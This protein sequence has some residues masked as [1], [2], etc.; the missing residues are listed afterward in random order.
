MI[1]SHIRRLLDAASS[2]AADANLPD[3]LRRIVRSACDLVDARYGALGVLGPDQKFSEFITVGIDQAERQGMGELP[4]GHGVLGLV[5]ADP[6][7]QRLADL[8]KHPDA[9]GFPPGH[10]P[11][12]SFLGVPIRVRETVFGNLYLTEKRGGEAFTERDEELVVALATAV[13][14]TIENAILFDKALRRERWLEASHQVTSALLA[15]EDPDATFRLIA[16]R[17]R[18]V[19]GASVTAIARPGAGDRSTLVFEVVEAEDPREQRQWAGVTVPVEGTATG[20][21]FTSGRPVVVRQYGDHVVAQE[22]DSARHIPALVKD[23]DSAVAVPLTVGA[24]TLGVLLVAKFRDSVPFTDADVQLVQAFAG[25]AALALE[26]SRAEGDRRRL[27]VFEDR[28]R[29]ARD[30]HDL[31]IQRLFATGLGLEGL[32]R[33]IVQPEV[34]ERM[35]A[36]VH[37]LDRTIRDVRNSIFSLQEPTEHRGSLRSELLGLALE[38]TEV[39]GFEPRIS[40]DGPLDTL[41]PD[42]V[43]SD[44]IATVREALSNVGRHAVATSVSADIMVDRQGRQLTVTVID[45]GVGIPDAPVRSSGLANLA[46]RA[47]RWKGTLSVQRIGERGTRLAWTVTLP[48]TTESE[49]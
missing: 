14:V 31:V 3:V 6:R 19:A 32:S 13:G 33:L 42:R 11:M 43:R 26:F 48:A 1:E 34:A 22:A 15:G 23:L 25:H 49:R 35:T 47:K 27:A 8:Q 9:C 45:D 4:T 20:M 38:S 2:V 24:E 7:S 41:V 21:A 37:D 46:E 17:A 39:L 18:V 40:F 29:I 5:I 10:P 28:D 36:F 30:L 16:E 12:R 44:L